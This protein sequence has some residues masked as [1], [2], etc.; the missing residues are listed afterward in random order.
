MDE[1]E[2]FEAHRDHLRSVAWRLLGDGAQ[3]ED[4][5]QEAWLRLERTD[6]SDVAN[7]GGWLT[8]V[9][10]RVALT[11][12]RARRREEPADAPEHDEPAR[13]TGPEDLAVRA[14]ELGVA[15]V[16]LLE[17][18][19]PAERLAFVL[20]DLFGVP[21]T[22]IAPIVERSPEATRQLASR[23]RRRVRG[24]RSGEGSTPIGELDP[25]T[26]RAPQAGADLAARQEVV[27]AFLAAARDGDFAGLLTVLDPGVELR[28]D[29][30]AVA[31]A[32]AGRGNGA[33]E[34]AASV[35]G[36]DAVA[37]VFAGRAQAARPALLDGWP[38]AFY[39]VGG[40]VRSVF[41]F[42]VV[43][44]RI[45]GVEVLADPATLAAIALEPSSS[46]WRS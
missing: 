4:A 6:V 7:L 14:D 35:R 16:V 2:L 12:L 26:R 19:A 41:R 43:G 36:A 15:L 18:L 31:A 46:E 21:F 27:T 32:E 38:G 1:N 24:R 23:A 37:R 28:A 9:T 33:P 10:A 13:D 30:V 20:H 5:V 8:T 42:T 22:E 45:A 11:M 44:G 3:A 40:A 17:T 29:P 25:T 34:L 39:A